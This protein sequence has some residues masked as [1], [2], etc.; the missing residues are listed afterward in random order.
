[1]KPPI[2]SSCEISI[3][4]ESEEDD[5]RRCGGEEVEAESDAEYLYYAG[6]FSEDYD[7]KEWT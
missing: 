5:E 1:M 2:L 4:L 6:F 7:D 3:S